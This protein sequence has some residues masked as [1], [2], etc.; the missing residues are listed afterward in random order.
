MKKFIVSSLVV[1]L[2]LMGGL[3]ARAANDTTNL[4]LAMGPGTL[5]IEAPDSAA[6][7]GQTVS[8]DDQ[9]TAAVIGDA[10]H[11]NAVGI[12]VVDTRGGNAGW[13]NTM[14]VTNLTFRGDAVMTA[15]SNN[16]VTASGTYDGVLGTKPNFPSFIVKITTAGLGNGAA[17]YSYWVPGS[18]PAGAADGVD[19]ATSGTPTELSNGVYVAFT[20]ATSY[21]ANDEW[22][23]LVDVLPYNDTPASTGL[24]ITPSDIYNAKGSLTEVSK[25]SANQFFSGSGVTSDPLTVMTASIHHGRGSY[26][27]DVDMVQDIHANSAA[28]DYS[29][30][31]TLDAT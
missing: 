21:S 23:I 11:S 13:S 29:S 22:S 10:T 14:T 30:I 7:A 19:V 6:F 25:G 2:I 5:T 26:Y 12:H 15:G 3:V 27:I 28:G 17:K 1:G 31:A 20:E 16:D 24:E 4:S 18:D 8:L 9:D